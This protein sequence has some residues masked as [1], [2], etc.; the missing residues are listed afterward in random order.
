MKF[1]VLVSALA[2]LGVS[3]QYAPPAPPAPAPAAYAPA[4]AP[5][6]VP[7]YAAPVPAPAQCEQCSFAG[8]ASYAATCGT[9]VQDQAPI[10]TAQIAG[11]GAMGG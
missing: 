2:A 4:P 10:R 3:G 8:K 5:A 11:M 6:P 7:V 9:A 1:V